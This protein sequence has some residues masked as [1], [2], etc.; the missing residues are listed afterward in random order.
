MGTIYRAFDRELD[1]T[2]AVKMLQP[3]IGVGIRGL[4]RLK[5]EIILASRVSDDHVVRVHDLGEL[6]G[7][8]VIVMDWVDGEN[9]S[10]LLQKVR[11]LP[12][13]QV[14]NFA[15]QICRAL[16]V[17][18]KAGIIHRDIKPGNLLVRKDGEIV[19]TDFGLACSSRPE[20]TQI[21][22]TDDCGGTARYMAPETLAGLPADVR[23][24]L[25]SLGSVLLEMLT[26]TT[27][28]E[29][30][31]SVRTRLLMSS[32]EREA[33]STELRK[34][35]ALNVVIRRCLEPDRTERYR[36]S[37]EILEVLK[38]A[39]HATP[40]SS[41]ADST[42]VSGRLAAAVLGLRRPSVSLPILLF[43]LVLVGWILGGY[44][45]SHGRINDA[46]RHYAKAVQA[47]N[48]QKGEAGLRLGIRDLDEALAIQPRHLFALRAR[49]D[50]LLRLYELTNDGK[51][52]ATAR[53]SLG[54]AVQAGLRGQ[55]FSLI[56]ARIDLYSGRNSDAIRKLESDPLLVS[57]SAD[58]N[59]LLGRALEAS[60]QMESAIAHYQL[61]IRL[62][63]ESW[64]AYN[65]LGSARL[66]SGD[67]EEAKSL[68]GRV[69][70]L[71]P[72]S[73][74]GYSNL[75]LA[76]LYSGDLSGARRNFEVALQKSRSA[77]TYNNL[78][79]A[80]YYAH[81]FASS[82]PF[83][84]SAINLRPGSDRYLSGLGDAFRYAGEREQA[85][86]AYMGA[87]DALALVLK[88]RNLSVEEQC[89]RA[90]VLAFLGDVPAAQSV[91]SA[92]GSANSDRMIFY[93]R[94]VLVMLDGEK[95]RAREQLTSAVRSGYPEALAKMDPDLAALFSSAQPVN[96][97]HKR[98]F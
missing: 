48:S 23:S 29:S 32:S 71:H 13:S 22:R 10:S 52:L 82:I 73:P 24:D 41:Y 77:E 65:E 12:P 57:S 38:M 74:A 2:V 9:L 50:A 54:S 75:G 25:Y 91:M 4:L 30:L 34:L 21:A 15:A 16:V 72:D 18:H 39:E 81:E 95:L 92:L 84:Q 56:Q 14:C 93:T 98:L 80:A 87:L 69:T 96:S 85:Q 45:R 58:A 68:F 66:Q 62:N 89:R 8:A 35:A 90:R 86:E 53:E 67:L 55:Q 59:R 5:R 88:S 1:R 33:R 26:G 79:V 70:E 20:D 36:S 43:S 17:I 49:L 6:D 46:N 3:P 60:Q 51:A 61:A 63:P 31:E 47:L 11:T 7:R 40:I 27:A 78:G 28:V 19:I 83:F 44:L 94:A 76:L 42:R 64:L 97:S 37:E